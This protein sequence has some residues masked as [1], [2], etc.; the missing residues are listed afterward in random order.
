MQQLLQHPLWTGNSFMRKPFQSWPIKHLTPKSSTNGITGL[1]PKFKGYSN[2]P[3]PSKDTGFLQMNIEPD[4]FVRQKTQGDSELLFINKLGVAGATSYKRQF[5]EKALERSGQIIPYFL[6]KKGIEQ[7]EEQIR[8]GLGVEHFSELLARHND[9]KIALGAVAYIL[10]WLP[11]YRKTNFVELQSIAQQ[12]LQNQAALLVKKSLQGVR[13]KAKYVEINGYPFQLHRKLLSS[14][15]PQLSAIL[16]AKT[17][18]GLAI[19]RHVHNIYHVLDFNRYDA[20][21]QA[22]FPSYKYK[23][24]R[25]ALQAI[26]NGCPKCARIKAVR[27]VSPGGPLLPH[28]F[29]A[30]PLYFATTGDLLGPYSYYQGRYKYK[31]WISVFT[32]DSSGHTSIIPID[33]FG[34]QGVIKHINFVQS[35]YGQIRI[36]TTD[37]GSAYYGLRESSDKILAEETLSTRAQT[38]AKDLALAQTKDL[39]LDEMVKIEVK[40]LMSYTN[41]N[42]IVLNLSPPKSQK[43]SGSAELIVR[44]VKLHLSK[45]IQEK[46]SFSDYWALCTDMSGI[47]NMRPVGFDGSAYITRQSLVIGG[48]QDINTNAFNALCSQEQLKDQLEALSKARDAFYTMIYLYQRKHYLKLNSSF[49]PTE[50]LQCGDLVQVKSVKNLMGNPGLGLIEKLLDTSQNSVNRTVLVLMARPIRKSQAAFPLAKKTFEHKLFKRNVEDLILLA[51]RKDVQKV[52]LDPSFPH[53]LNGRVDDREAVIDFSAKKTDQRGAKNENNRPR[54]FDYDITK[55]RIDP[56]TYLPKKDPGF[57][58]NKFLQ[59]KKVQYHIGT[60]PVWSDPQFPRETYLKSNIKEQNTGLEEYVGTVKSLHHT[61][62][63]SAKLKPIIKNK[64]KSPKLNT[65]IRSKKVTFNLPSLGKEENSGSSKTT[66]SAN[67]KENSGSSKT[68]SS[69]NIKENSGSSKTTSSTNIKENDGNSSQKVRRSTRGV[70]KVSYVGL[71]LLTLLIYIIGFLAPANAIRIPPQQLC[72]VSVNTKNLEININNYEVAL[73]DWRTIQ[74]CYANQFASS[75]LNMVYFR[76][77][78][79][80]KTLAE[81]NSECRNMNGR[82]LQFQNNQQFTDVK[83]AMIKN[84]YKSFVQHYKLDQEANHF[85]HMDGSGIIFPNNVNREKLLSDNQKWLLR[86]DNTM[87]KYILLKGETLKEVQRQCADSMGSLLIMRGRNEADI[88]AAQFLKEGLENI[89]ID[90][91]LSVELSLLAVHI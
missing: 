11:K 51:K 62:P 31:L 18:Y 34:S 4:P 67:I 77:S 87:Q 2:N 57:S 66:S 22:G 74:L 37:Y 83:Q 85:L 9:I 64:Q 89:N 79:N 53:N 17:S 35:I 1:M 65:K 12:K 14:Q 91:Y 21:L 73:E 59:T 20:Y 38:K 45:Q 40:S 24:S 48:Q 58:P 50:Q 25:P 88:L 3:L 71:A 10:S 26:E 27:I 75:Q 46:W 82:V 76:P 55:Y 60:S 29:T 70:G 28:K 84:G 30:S 15:I 90:L 78:A 33:T 6:T 52:T 80:I 43:Y 68:T 56:A 23:D 49:L 72:P 41:R 61:D 7:N 5:V 54:I 8:Q 19:L 39:D 69:D 13:N 47:L 32:D 81:A 63:I 16:S 36:L 44:F 86:G 42:G